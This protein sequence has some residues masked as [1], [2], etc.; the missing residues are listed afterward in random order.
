M[1]IQAEGLSEIQRGDAL[2]KMFFDIGLFGKLA[3]PKIAYREYCSLHQ[4]IFEILYRKPAKAA[5]IAPRGHSKTSCAS[6]IGTLHDIAYDLEDVI[7]MI[8]KT[9]IHAARDLRA[10]TSIVRHGEHFKYFFGDYEFEKDV[11]SDVIIKHKTTG[12]R[13]NIMA[14]GVEQ[15]IRGVNFEN[16]RP[17][18]FLLDDFETRENTQTP[19]MRD[20]NELMLS[21]DVEP[22]VNVERGSL[23]IIGTVPHYDSQLWKIKEAFDGGDRSW[24][25]IYRQILEDGK[26]IWPAMFPMWKV[27][28]LKTDYENRG[29][30]NV[31]FQEYMNI[32]ITEEMRALGSILY[33]DQPLLEH[34][35]MWVLETDGEK[36]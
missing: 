28:Q 30:A 27:E 19:E 1:K 12:H 11:E 4:Q 21:A 18:K 36:V 35:G 33:Y 2:Q 17:T 31:F 5:I 29:L 22:A 13:M 24:Q 32:P 7:V 34:E 9:Q 20:K 26:P 25:V 8:K 16:I 3:T 6:T 14:Y 15:D 23:F 10:I